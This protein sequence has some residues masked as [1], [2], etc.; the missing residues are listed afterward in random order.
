M[1]LIY[2]LSD[3]HG[4]YESMLDTLSLVDLDSDKENKLL[5][6]GDYVDRGKD[7]CKVLYH[8]KKMDEVYPNQ[9]EVLIGNHDEMFMDWFTLKD[10]DDWHP[11]ISYYFDTLKSFLG[12]EFVDSVKNLPKKPGLFFEINGMALTGMRKRHSDLQDWLLSKEKNRF[13]ENKKNSQI[14]L[15]AGLLEEAGDLWKQGTP[16]SYFTQKFPAE[17]G[18]FYMDIIAG[19]VSSATAAKNDD[20]LGKVYYDGKSH[21]YIDGE[22]ERS[23]IVPLLKFNTATGVYSSYDKATNGSWVEYKIKG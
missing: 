20:Y 10:K 12:A 13:F 1:S 23:C 9:V 15:H 19:H 14:Y 16:D 3:I 4:F 6:L 2:A 22:T 8:V 5:F 17:T 7:S 21:F 18:S 11:W